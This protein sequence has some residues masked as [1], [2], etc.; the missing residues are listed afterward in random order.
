MIPNLRLPCDPILCLMEMT[1]D[2]VGGRAF[3]TFTH[4]QNYAFVS[5]LPGDVVF[6]YYYLFHS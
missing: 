3:V 1:S 2:G 4:N 5:I 6:A